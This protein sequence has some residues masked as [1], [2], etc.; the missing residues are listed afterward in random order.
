M[1]VKKKQRFK[2]F[3]SFFFLAEIVNK[4]L[5][6]NVFFFHFS[7]VK[8]GLLM[9]NM[10]MISLSKYEISFYN[11]TLVSLITLNLTLDNNLIKS[12]SL[13]SLLKE[14]IASDLQLNNHIHCC[15]I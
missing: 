14:H 12:S 6:L 5:G 2:V 11:K 1:L 4:G 10:E 7:S 8:F 13:F 9:L 3:F 15:K